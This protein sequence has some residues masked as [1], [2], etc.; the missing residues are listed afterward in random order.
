[1]TG[2]FSSEDFV[3]LSDDRFTSVSAV[4]GD[5]I[6]SLYEL[7]V[8]RGAFQGNRRSVMHANIIAKD[9]MSAG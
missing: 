4:V 9:Q 6:K 2:V 8:M 7:S 5:D 1:M 3:R